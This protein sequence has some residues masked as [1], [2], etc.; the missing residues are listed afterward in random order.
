MLK[1]FAEKHYIQRSDI[2]SNDLILSFLSRQIF[3]SSYTQVACSTL[4]LL[5]SS[6]M[7]QQTGFDA[8]VISVDSPWKIVSNYSIIFRQT[9]R[10]TNFAQTFM[11]EHIIL[12]IWPPQLYTLA[13]LKILKSVYKFMRLSILAQA[14]DQLASHGPVYE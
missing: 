9:R 13:N 4:N 3:P 6:L 10:L 11:Y 5:G 14:R 7:E 8:T 12:Y 1:K 2:H